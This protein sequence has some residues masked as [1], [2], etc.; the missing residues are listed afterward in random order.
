M[1]IKELRDVYGNVKKTSS[2]LNRAVRAECVGGAE[3]LDAIYIAAK[4]RRVSAD[5]EKM[6]QALESVRAAMQNEI[7]RRYQFKTAPQVDEAERLENER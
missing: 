1:P 7:A 4:N 5:W 2:L 3:L 6:F